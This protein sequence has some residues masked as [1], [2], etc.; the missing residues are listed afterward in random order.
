MKKRWSI[1]RTKNIDFGT[2]DVKYYNSVEKMMARG[3][4]IQYVHVHDPTLLIKLLRESLLLKCLVAR[5]EDV[6]TVVL[7]VYLRILTN[8]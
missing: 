5:N 1:P 8:G 7:N 3:I 6:K 2:C 4:R